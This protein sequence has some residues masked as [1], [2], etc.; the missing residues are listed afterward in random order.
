MSF[1]VRKEISFFFF[2]QLLKALDVIDVCTSG[3]AL[4]LCVAATANISVQSNA[5]VNVL[6][7]HNAVKRLI[8]ALNRPKC[9]TVFVQEQVTI[10]ISVIFIVFNQMCRRLTKFWFT[11]VFLFF[12]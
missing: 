11:A 4:L 8:A 9:S 10:F 12:N 1:T 7:Q 3:E 5:V 6:Y 2:F